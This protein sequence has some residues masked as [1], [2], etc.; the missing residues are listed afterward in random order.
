MRRAVVGVVLALATA[1]C[2]PDDDGTVERSVAS[3]T[4]PT[5][6][7][8]SSTSAPSTAAVTA[9]A[10]TTTT[11]PVPVVASCPAPLPRAEPDPDRPRYD[12]T[13]TADPRT[14]QVVGEQRVA[15][16]P[17]L[18]VDRVVF[19]LWANGPRPAAAGTAIDLGE[20]REG[21][22]VRTVDRP[23]PT[24]AE[25]LLGRWVAPGETITLE[26]PWRLAVGGTAN[27]RISRQADSLRLGSFLPLLAWQPGTGWALEPPTSGFAESTTSPTADWQVTIGVP[28]GFGVVAT[29]TDAGG[30]RY[31]AEAVRDVAVAVGRFTVVSAVA[32]APHPVEVTVAVHDAV[33][34]PARYLDQL[35]HQLETLAG[36]YGPYPWPGYALSITPDLSGGIEFPMHVMQGPGTD[37]R[38]TPHE[39]AHMWFYGLVG[40]NQGRSPYLDEGIATY[41]EA[42]LLGT[43]DQLADKAIPADGRGRADAPMTYWETR[44]SSYYRSVYL[45]P[46]AALA[47]I[48]PPELVDCALARYVAANAHRIA[49]PED[50]AAAFD[51]V[52]PDWREAVAPAGLP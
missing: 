2:A 48:G 18:P 7:A 21:G 23:D 30:G 40:N 42:R 52:F 43:V 35:V 3:T 31:T 44:A 19:R 8:P 49:G 28:D 36:W 46:A 16:I 1:A 14:G 47:G 24:T 4:I 26:L 11:T 6:E 17:D 51:A 10:T 38:T 12:V 33:D 27:D 25:V 9:P 32:M 22:A 15:F 13:M 29:G 20:V 37:G 45:Q 5:S 50:F 34:D 41:V 39:V